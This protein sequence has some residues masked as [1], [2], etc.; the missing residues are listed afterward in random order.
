[1]KTAAKQ[2]IDLEKQYA[3]GTKTYEEIAM[4]INY[5]ETFNHNLLNKLFEITQGLLLVKKA[6]LEERY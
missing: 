3:L 4:K 1:M 2:Y 6:I 5:L